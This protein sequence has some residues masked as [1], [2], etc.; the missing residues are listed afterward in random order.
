MG[1]EY[2]FCDGHCKGCKLGYLIYL[3]GPNTGRNNRFRVK[4]T[5]D[6]CRKDFGTRVIK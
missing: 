1:I 2:V 5:Q 3:Y 4:A 6:I